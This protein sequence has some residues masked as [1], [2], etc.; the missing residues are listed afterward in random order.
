LTETL[1]TYEPDNSLKKGYLLIFKEI[2]SEIMKNRWLTYQLFRRDFL[3][4]YGQSIFGVLWAFV[5]PILSVSTFIILSVSGLFNVGTINVPYPIY[6]LVGLSFW[7][8]F[9][10]GVVAG[11][12]SLVKAGSLIVK[13]NFSKKSLVISS[14]GQ[15]LVSLLIQL[16]LAIFFFVF[17]GILPN[18]SILL[19]PVLILPMILI[20]LG[21]SFI[22]SIMN[23]VVRDFGNLISIGITFLLLLTPVMYAKPTTGALAWITNY[24]PL[25]YLVS[26]PRD[27]ILRGATTEWIGF[28]IS[29]L[30]SAVLFIIC[31]VAFH[32]T[33]TRLAERI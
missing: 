20:T 5:I 7:Q 11:S 31:L 8:L 23:G 22:L 30:L 13:I 25:Y 16:G 4:I 19:I 3:T 24:N 6:A 9:S 28:V 1:T 10:A 26:V 29:T 32:L 27:L 33:E 14:M 2:G 12:N 18:A 21:L 17:Y 15:P